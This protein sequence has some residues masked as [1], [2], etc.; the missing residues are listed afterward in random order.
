MN[1]TN[2][3]PRKRRLVALF[4]LPLAQV[5]CINFSGKLDAVGR[6]DAVFN[7]DKVV[8]ARCRVGG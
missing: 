1:N 8:T 4:L 3:V 7:P 2:T 5:S 6:K